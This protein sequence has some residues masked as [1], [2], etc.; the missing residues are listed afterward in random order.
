[1]LPGNSDLINRWFDITIFGYATR[2]YVL[3]QTLFETLL[4]NI[5]MDSNGPAFKGCISLPTSFTLWVADHIIWY[6]WIYRINLKIG[7]CYISK[8]RNR[9]R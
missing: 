9:V 4:M 6:Y 2:V 3:G 1:M 8:H 7:C 5:N